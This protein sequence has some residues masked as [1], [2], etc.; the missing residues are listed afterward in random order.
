VQRQVRKIVDGV[1]ERANVANI[2]MLKALRAIHP[3]VGLRLGID[4]TAAKA[5]VRQVGVRTDQ[6]EAWLRRHAPT[7]GASDGRA[8]K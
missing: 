1:P 7:A 2:E 3:T 5:W 4:G 8:A 6:E